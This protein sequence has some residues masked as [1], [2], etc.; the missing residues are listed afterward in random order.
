[1]VCLHNCRCCSHTWAD[2]LVVVAQSSLRAS[3]LRG[4]LDLPFW[5]QA[6]SYI[7]VVRNT[8]RNEAKPRDKFSCFILTLGTCL[9][10]TVMK[11]HKIL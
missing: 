3:V 6:S 11:C 10:T 4:E 5:F 2:E 9:P 7:P 1:M 8:L